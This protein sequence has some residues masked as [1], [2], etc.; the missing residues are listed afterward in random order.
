MSRVLVLG[1]TGWV[2]SAVVRALQEAGEDVGFTWHENAA[3][4]DALP[5]HAWKID[6]TTRDAVPA[7]FRRMDKD[8]W[9]PDSLV[10]A[11]GLRARGPGEAAEPWES[12]LDRAVALLLRT[13]IAACRELAARP[14]DA[15][16]R[17]VVL[18]GALDRTQSFP[19]APHLAA[20]QG[21]LTAAA[22]A[23]GHE[24]GPRGFRVNVVALGLLDGGAAEDVSTEQRDAYKRFSALRRVGTAAETAATAVWLVRENRVLNGKV[25]AA[26]GGI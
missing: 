1:G 10:C 11:V 15:P 17:N 22:M 21:G 16:V 26:N 14:T 5:G 23:L 19:I 20:A 13:P 3:L 4:S 12:A 2:G 8:G 9:T 25:L 18:L 7:L 24:L 6:L